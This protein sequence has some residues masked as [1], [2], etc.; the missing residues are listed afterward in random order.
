MY[1]LGLVE[2]NCVCLCICDCDCG[3]MG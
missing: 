2:S 1:G 3:C